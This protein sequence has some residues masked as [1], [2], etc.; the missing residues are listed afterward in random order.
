MIKA[1]GPLESIDTEGAWE[2]DRLTELDGAEDRKDQLF[3]EPVVD[4]DVAGGEKC[5]SEEFH[6]RVYKVGPGGERDAALL[7]EEPRYM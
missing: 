4:G 3:G 7:T 5:G 6:G 2:R 1:G